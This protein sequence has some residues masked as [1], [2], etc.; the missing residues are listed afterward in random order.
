MLAYYV[1]WHMRRALAP[2]LFDDEHKDEAKALSDSVVAPA[3]RSEH[4][5][6]KAQERRTEDGMPVHSFQTLLQDLA[7]LCRN[8]VRIKTTDATFTD[9]TTPTPVQEKAFM[10]LQISP[11][12]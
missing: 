1:E 6:Q 5:E 8:T 11:V 2:M 9:F 12:L 4:A 10:L 7:T 3:R